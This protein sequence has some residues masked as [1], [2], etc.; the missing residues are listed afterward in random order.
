MAG[1]PKRI[2][3]KR[4]KGWRMPEGAI[5]VGRG[6]IWGNPFIV[7]KPS[8]VFAEG[9]GF[10]GRA[11]VMIPALTLEQAVAFYRDLINGIIEPEMHPFGHDWMANFKNKTNGWHP[12][13]AVRSILR[14]HSLMCFCP[15]DQP[16][17]ADV[18]LEISNS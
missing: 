4:T 7:G 9:F 17:H 10:Q 12:A 5:Y 2:Q 18:L 8:G 14:G 3:R 16:C 13:E 6:T 1:E 11:E 15:L